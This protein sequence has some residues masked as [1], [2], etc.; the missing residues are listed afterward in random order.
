MSTPYVPIPAPYPRSPKRSSRT[1]LVLAIS[2]AFILLIL[3]VVGI[4]SLI[5]NSDVCKAAI[6]K[7]QANA[8]VVEGLGE[9]IKRGWVVQGH[10]E[11]STGSG[12]ADLAIPLSGSKRK[13]TLYAVAVKSAGLW[14]FET[15]QLDIEGDEKRIDLLEQTAAPAQ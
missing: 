3:F 9:P 11:V 5:G 15:L 10:I 8:A 2:G 6:E 12:H 14:K 13:G 7:A 1:T 4:F